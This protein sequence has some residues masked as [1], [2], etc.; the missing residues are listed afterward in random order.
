MIDTAGNLDE[1]K[2]HQVFGSSD[3]CPQKLLVR[4]PTKSLV[5]FLYCVVFYSTEQGEQDL[6][7]LCTF[8][9]IQLNLFYDLSIFIIYEDFS[10]NDLT[11]LNEETWFQ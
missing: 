7:H 4:S 11:A 1:L 10:G 3:R 8:C 2:E 6:Q 9:F 5:P